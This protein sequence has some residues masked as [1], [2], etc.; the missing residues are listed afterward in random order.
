MFESFDFAVLGD[1][2]FKEDAVREELIVPILARL[3]YS[4]TGENRIV[5]SKRLE[6][7]FVRFG[8][9]RVS[10]TIIPDYLLSVGGE[11]KCVLD[12]KAP[13]EEIVSGKN[14]EQAYSYAMHRDVRA[15]VY[16]LCNGHHLIAFHIHKCEPILN[17]PLREIDGRW[18]EVNKALCPM[19][20]ID[21][22]RLE[23]FPD[24]G[25]AAL[26]AG[27]AN[28]ETVWFPWVPAQFLMKAADDVYM[29]SSVIDMHGDHCITFDFTSA[30]YQSLLGTLPAAVR[31]SVRT[32]LSRQPYQIS[33]DDE[34]PSLSIRATLAK[35]PIS[36]EQETYVPFQAI[37]VGKC[38]LSAEALEAFWNLDPE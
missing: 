1:P 29:L 20:F 6:H 22:E 13:S 14:V 25:L 10:V 19:A 15:S 26:K 2:D 4:A 3:G 37:E 12:A 36:N 35:E 7:P 21:P 16:C 17:V 23:F 9:T 5:R 34:P 18:A 27:W 11:T 24:F 32:A 8:T 30:L 38:E 28:F 31:Q 33:F